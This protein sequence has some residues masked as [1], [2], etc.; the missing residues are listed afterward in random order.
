LTMASARGST[1]HSLSIIIIITMLPIKQQDSLSSKTACLCRGAVRLAGM[2]VDYP[3]YFVH[4]AIAEL[5][6]ELPVFTVKGFDSPALVCQHNFSFASGR[7]DRLARLSIRVTGHDHLSMPVDMGTRRNRVTLL[8]AIQ[9]DCTATSL[10]DFS[11]L[12]ALQICMKKR[13]AACCMQPWCAYWVACRAALQCTQPPPL[14][15]AAAAAACTGSQ[16]TG[17]SWIVCRAALQC[18][19]VV[20][21]TLTTCTTTNHLAVGPRSSWDLGGPLY[22][23]R[24]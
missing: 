16:K 24:A 12:T 9:H 7:L 15:L 3:F 5:N 19:H 14:S 18:T 4:V 1:Q 13:K 22:T 11:R 6:A 17:V 10:E 8:F 2:T 21:N 20:I 23:N